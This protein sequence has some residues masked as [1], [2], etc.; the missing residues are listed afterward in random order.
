MPVYLDPE[1]N[2]VL[3]TPLEE[4]ALESYFMRKSYEEHRVWIDSMLADAR[5]DEPLRWSARCEGEL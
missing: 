1:G 3:D 4:I 2:L 5:R